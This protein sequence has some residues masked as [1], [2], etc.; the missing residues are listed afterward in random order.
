MNFFLRC[1]NAFKHPRASLFNHIRGARWT[2]LLSDKT[3]L[4]IIYY[5]RVNKILHFKNPKSF[6][7]KLQWLKVYNRDPLYTILVDKL[8]SK[9]WVANKIGQEHII[10]FLGVYDKWEDIDFSILP[11]Q[12]VIKC[13]HNCGV[14]ICTDKNKLDINKAKATIEKSLHENYYYFSREWPYKNVPPKI[15]IEKYMVDESGTELKDYKFF[16]FNGE[17][18]L[19]FIATDRNINDVKFDFFDM[20]FNHLPIRNGHDNASHLITKPEKFDEMIEIA[21][22]LSKDIPHVRVDLY[23]INGTIYFGEM[24]FFHFGGMTPFEPEKWD[25]EI[26]SWL[27]LPKKRK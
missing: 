17:P 9:K 13:T 15:L 2:H 4:R 6:N 12:F 14:V 19:F 27:E 20:D 23:N 18:K 25:Y 24:T 26:G 7:E 3:Y 11:D 8:K 22:T 5:L 21:R 1:F 16:C 10:P